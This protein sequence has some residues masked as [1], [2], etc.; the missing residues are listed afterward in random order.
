MG[1]VRSI[2]LIHVETN[3]P[4]QKVGVSGRALG[5]CGGPDWPENWS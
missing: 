4:G 3:R 2:I 5:K 1:E